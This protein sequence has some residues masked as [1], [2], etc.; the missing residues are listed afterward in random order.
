[1]K[2]KTYLEDK[3]KK[4]DSTGKE[5]GKLVSGTTNI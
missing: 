4:G 1:M 5:E 3:K 2:K